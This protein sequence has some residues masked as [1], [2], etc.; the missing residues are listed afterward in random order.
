[1]PES[2]SEE[3][4]LQLIKPSFREIL[5]IGI[6]TAGDAEM[7]MAS[8]APQRHITATTLDKNGAKLVEQI[9]FAAHLDDRITVLV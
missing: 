6:S 7:K 8:L 5:S 3:T 9:L 4:G 1:M 2:I